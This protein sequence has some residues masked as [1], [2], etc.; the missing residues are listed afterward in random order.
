MFLYA[1]LSSFNHD[2]SSLVSGNN[3]FAYSKLVSFDSNFYKLTSADYMFA[4]C[5][6]LTNFTVRDGINLGQNRVYNMFIGSTALKNWDCGLP[7]V[8]D[9]NGVFDSAVNFETFT[10]DL[11][12]LTVTPTIFKNKS[13][14]TS[15]EA[16]LSSLETGNEMF[17]N[18]T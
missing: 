4:F 15:F 11:S 9:I 17:F 12:S 7:Y 5:N 6:N 16:D 13:S 1:G 8:T 10:S 14:L 18:S 3:M 2:L